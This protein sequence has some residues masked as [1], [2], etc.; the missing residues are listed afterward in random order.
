MAEYK[1]PGIDDVL[2]E[3]RTYIHSPESLAL[4]EQAANYASEH[5]AG[6]FRRSG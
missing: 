3:A 1:N 6:Q 5:H 2:A 4:I